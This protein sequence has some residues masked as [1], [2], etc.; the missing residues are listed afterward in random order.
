MSVLL[1]LG[2]FLSHPFN[3]SIVTFGKILLVP[4]L[5]PLCKGWGFKVCHAHNEMGLLRWSKDHLIWNLFSTCN[6]TLVFFN[7]LKIT[8]FGNL[9]QWKIMSF[10]TCPNFHMNVIIHCKT[11]SCKNVY[12][13]N[14]CKLG[15]ANRSNFIEL[16]RNIF[17]V[18]TDDQS[19]LN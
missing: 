19:M 9:S 18:D 11:V 15:Q 2:I 3:P 7:D 17:S 6:K 1:P 5:R 16:G 12:N 14:N 8:W 13:L 10:R 4:S